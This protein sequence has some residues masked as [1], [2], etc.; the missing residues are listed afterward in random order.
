MSSTVSTNFANSKKRAIR[1]SDKGTYFVMTADGK[2]SYGPKA[3]FK[4]TA[5]GGMVKLTAANAVPAKIKAARVSATPKAKAPAGPRKPRANKGVARGPREGTLQRRMNANAKKRAAAGPRKVRSNKG[6]ARGPREGT[7][8]RR[9]NANAK[10][11]AARAPLL[12]ARRARATAA[13]V[14][15][16]EAAARRQARANAA[17]AKKAEMAVRRQARANAAAAKKAAAAAKKAA[18]RKV[19]ANKGVKRGPRTPTEA[20]LYQMIFGP[21]KKAVKEIKAMIVSPGGTT[22][23]SRGAAKAAATR[24]AKQARLNKNPYALLRK[25]NKK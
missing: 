7:V 14:K 3:A 4:K 22:Y 10:K 25:A 6:V 5:N 11:Q 24:K 20:A 2:R 1:L 18:G 12:A 16:A 23:K 21:E 15:K 13:A 19:R 9:M 17:A 8:Q